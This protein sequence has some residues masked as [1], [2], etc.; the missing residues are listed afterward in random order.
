MD[1]WRHGNFVRHYASRTLRPPEVILLAR[2]AHQMQGDVLE[3]GCGAGRVSGY[4]VELARSLHG[5]DVSELMVDHCRQ[6]YPAGKFTVMDLRDLS[7]FDDESFDCVFAANSVL[8]V[9][10]DQERRE[11]LREV[12]RI[13]RPDGVLAMASHNRA[14]IPRLRKPTDIR[15]ARNLVRAFGK[16]VLMPWRLRNQRRL[17][18]LLRTESDYALVNDDA[19]DFRL[20]HYYISNDAQRLQFEQ[21]GF[22]PIEC[23]DSQGS[24]VAEGAQADE[25]AELHYAARRAPTGPQ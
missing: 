13:L 12:R 4:L 23:L 9:L 19:H 10:G 2:H 17:A 21:E 20:L 18:P 16:L 8:D 6:A 14:H 25:S 3:L 22:L 5:I 15:G 24:S 11:V 1:V 7:N